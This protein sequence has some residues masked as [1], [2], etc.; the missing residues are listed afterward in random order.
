MKDNTI[1][2]MCGMIAIFLAF[3]E[4]ITGIYLLPITMLFIMMT[5]LYGIKML[6][7][8]STINDEEE[9]LICEGCNKAVKNLNPCENCGFENLGFVNS[10]EDEK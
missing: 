7:F 4:V 10:V 9:K 3:I 5:L 6:S 2:G 1:G 8:A